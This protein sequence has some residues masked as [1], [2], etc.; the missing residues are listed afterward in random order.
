MLRAGAVPPVVGIRAPQVNSRASPSGAST[1]LPRFQQVRF[2]LSAK[3]YSKKLVEAQAAL[4]AAIEQRVRGGC[5]A[6]CVA[7]GGVGRQLVQHPSQGDAQPVRA[8]VQ[9]VVHL[10]KRLLQ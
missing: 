6:L 5:R 1:R 8:V 10:V 2:A 3:R 7:A 4:A 9:F